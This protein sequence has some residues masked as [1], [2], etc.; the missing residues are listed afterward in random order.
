MHVKK[1][2]T[3]QET[4]SRQC[5]GKSSCVKKRRGDPTN[6]RFPRI[7]IRGGGVRPMPGTRCGAVEGAAEDN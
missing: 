3:K 4:R 1:P 7:T 5:K 2:E 6:L